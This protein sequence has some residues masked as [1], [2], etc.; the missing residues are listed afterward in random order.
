[1]QNVRSE[2]AWRAQG[3]ILHISIQGFVEEPDMLD[4]VRAFQSVVALHGHC[5]VILNVHAMTGV[6]PA[7][8][9]RFE[10]WDVKGRCRGRVILGARLAAKTLISVI[11]MGA[12]MLTGRCE[13]TAFLASEE[14]AMLWIAERRAQLGLTVT[15]H[16]SA[17]SGLDA[18]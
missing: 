4:F 1:M 8:R 3:D 16:P 13:P 17:V 9:R 15:A 2:H 12:R 11:L 14:A 7:A 6:S 18:G 5:L 10:S